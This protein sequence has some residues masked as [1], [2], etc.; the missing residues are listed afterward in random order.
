MYRNCDV[1]I[2]EIWALLAQFSPKPLAQRRDNGGVSLL[3]LLTSQ[4]VIG[5]AVGEAVGKTLLASGN[6]ITSIEIEERDLGRQRAATGGDSLGDGRLRNG[7][8]YDNR[9]VT[10]G[11]GI[12]R[13]R[14][15]S[16]AR[17][18]YLIESLQVELH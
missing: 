10:L 5:R 16:W 18:G 4:S 9:Q 3:D 13:D 7:S 12:A 1:A 6:A 17:W 11:G 14:F 15:G 2:R 8:V